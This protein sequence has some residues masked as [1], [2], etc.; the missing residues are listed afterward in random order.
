MQAEDKKPCENTDILEMRHI[1][2]HTESTEVPDLN[3]RVV[4]FSCGFL[5]I[6]SLVFL[7]ASQRKQLN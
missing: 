3:F 5:D 6:V 1:K 2:G 4:D 7:N